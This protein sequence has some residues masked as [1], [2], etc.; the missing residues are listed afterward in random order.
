MHS[1]K[2]EV[3]WTF[4]SFFPQASAI[5]SSSTSTTNKQADRNG[6]EEQTKW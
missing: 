5:N 2:N 3:G 6:D 1:R 4:D